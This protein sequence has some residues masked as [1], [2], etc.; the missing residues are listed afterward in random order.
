MGIEKY[1]ALKMGR[2]GS[3]ERVGSGGD[4][5]DF[6]TVGTIVDSDAGSGTLQHSGNVLAGSCGDDY[7]QGHYKRAKEMGASQ[8][9]KFEGSGLQA[10]MAEAACKPKQEGIGSG[11]APPGEMDVERGA[12]DVCS[13]SEKI[14]GH[15]EH[16]GKEACKDSAQR[17]KEEEKEGAEQQAVGHGDDDE[18][19]DEAGERDAPKV[20]GD[21][22]ERGELG[23]KGHGKKRE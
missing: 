4:E 5:V 9:G 12:R 19:A 11:N 7:E 15:T 17:H 3:E 14:V 2:G 16:A 1:V 22:G 13:V 8:T 21:E 18:G 10:A 23:Y 20:V 6:C